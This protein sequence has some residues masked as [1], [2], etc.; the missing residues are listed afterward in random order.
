MKNN[1]LQLDEDRILVEQLRLLLSNMSSMVIPV[2]I[3]AALMLWVFS[4]N[5]NVL[6]LTV[7]CMSTILLILYGYSYARHLLVT[8]IPFEQAHHIARML[9]FQ[10]IVNGALWGALA[11]VTLGTSSLA[12]S[13]LVISV[14]AGI[15]GGAVATLSPVLP[16]SV[17]FVILTLGA[18]A[19][20]LW[21]MGNPDYKILGIT[22]VLY[23]VTLLGQAR[24][25]SRAARGAI[26]LRFENIELMEKLRTKTAIAEAEQRKAELANITKSKFLAAAS[27][28]LRQP[29]H[30]QGLFLDV[31]SRTNL[32]AQQHELITSSWAAN[33]SSAE[34]L[35][36]LLDF[37]RIE[38]GVIEPRVQAFYLQPLLNKIERE[39]APQADAKGLAYR[40]RET[41]LIAQSDPA[42]L[43]L[44]MRN[45]VS[46]AIR[47]TSR[48]GLLVVFRKRGAQVVLEVRD[49]GIGIE[50]SQQHE[51]FREFHQLGNP[52]R[53]RH[54]G[55]GLG[56]AIVAGL[57]R[58][59]EHEF[60]LTSTP[61]R[62]SVFRVF[63]PL[64]TTLPVP[65]LTQQSD[66]VA[67][68]NM[69]VLVIDDDET[70][71]DSM[72]YLLRDWGC[73]CEA[74]DSIEDAV[75]LTR[76]NVPD[77]IISDYR[78]RAQCTGAEAIA[79]LRTLV[80]NP[81][82]PALLITGDTAPER[83]REAHAS[84]IPLLHKPVSPTRLY[85]GLIEILPYQIGV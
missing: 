67:L 65:S 47:Y 17:A 48:G 22:G 18:T 42:L 3:V 6:I 4:N 37:S 45:L 52:E 26:N 43:E 5:S 32:T 79:T 28:D 66:K 8:G 41:T 10:H 83:L 71:R 46:N 61:H 56:L 82:L 23:I 15:A 11:W 60:S 81:E 24:T 40:S 74:A 2:S 13:I 62:G 51:V 73:V 14:I 44:I 27:H 29:I 72:L 7:W 64:A 70:V 84:G 54:K 38:A 9:I 57:S 76:V 20:K 19:L 16:V 49:T 68:P 36:T 78:L 80:G 1:P 12:G 59:L 30:A 35:N 33:E 53:D 58:T 77:A 75:A 69:R 31:L 50:A 63:L 55:L 25:S 39:F 85:H 34:M 21:S